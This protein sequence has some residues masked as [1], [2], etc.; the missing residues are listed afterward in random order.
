MET[1]KLYNSPDLANKIKETAKNKG[2]TL[3]SLLEYCELGSNTFSHMLHGKSIAYNS[4]ANIA[5]YLE[6]SIDFLLG[7]SNA[8]LDK[9]ED[10]YRLLKAYR[11]LTDEGKDTILSTAEL[12][13]QSPKYQKYTD[14]PKAM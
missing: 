6:C 1:K 9:T 13:A 4:L 8:E 11:E 2:K 3:K 14:V 5:D 12:Y 7:R 10:E